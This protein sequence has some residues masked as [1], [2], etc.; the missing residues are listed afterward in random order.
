M[1][2]L[3]KIIDLVLYSNF[4]IAICAAAMVVQTQFVLT[5]Q[6][7]INALTGLVFFSTLFLYAIHRIIGISKVKD[8][9]EME[10]F[11]VISKF[12][13]H[14]TIYAV[15]AA[16]GGLYTFWQLEN[17]LKL[18]LIVPAMISLGYV[19][20]IFGK[21]RRLRDFDQ[22]KIVLIAVVWALITVVMVVLDQGENYF[23][24]EQ[25]HSFLLLTFERFC[26]VF[27]ITIPFDIRDLK[28]D[29]ATN[30][31][32]IPAMLG[33]QK[34]MYFAYFL[35]FMSML[36]S[37]CSNVF[38]GNEMGIIISQIIFYGLTMYMISKTDKIVHDYF[39]SGLMD[40]TM[41]FS[42]LF[43][44]FGYLIS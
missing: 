13:N 22:I 34:S 19:L 6:I 44:V 7:Q 14:I 43:V 31:K 29:Q 8:F 20:P 12:K 40:G 17:V 38:L 35:V 4:W 42:L 9:L 21:K 15:L 16:I 39:Y 3:K 26:F 28:V 32:T 23:R 11:A 41:L 33:V 2:F 27:A 24:N 25:T 30:V 1:S 36:S 37:V 18:F 5:Q 10:R